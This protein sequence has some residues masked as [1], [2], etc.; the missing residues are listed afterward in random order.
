MCSKPNL[1][2][3]MNYSEQHNYKDPGTEFRVRDWA[4]SISN[5]CMD[6]SDGSSGMGVWWRGTFVPKTNF[7]VFHDMALNKF[8]FF[9]LHC[10]FHLISINK[11]S[12]EPILKLKYAYLLQDCTTRSHDWD[13]TVNRSSSP[14]CGKNG[15]VKL[16]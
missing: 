9:L 10:V 4:T 5:S 2:M 14:P 13:G 7:H 12:P 8:D 6:T 1:N 16:P 3:S 15:T 11:L